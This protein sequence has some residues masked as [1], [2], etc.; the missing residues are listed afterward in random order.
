LRQIEV[1]KEK[2]ERQLREQAEQMTRQLKEQQEQI[3]F[4]RRSTVKGVR[5]MYQTNSGLVQK[6]REA[7]E[8]CKMIGLN[9]KFKQVL[10][11][12]DSMTYRS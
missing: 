10:V 4:R 5:D 3:E 1:Q 11:V 9:I 6:I 7:N 12:D 8:I 2:N